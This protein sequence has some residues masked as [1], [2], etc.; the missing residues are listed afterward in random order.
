MQKPLSYLAQA[1]FER[2]LPVLLSQI[3]KQNLGVLTDEDLNALLPDE[4]ADDADKG[5]MDRIARVIE[6]TNREFVCTFDPQDPENIEPEKRAREQLDKEALRRPERDLIRLYLLQ[7]SQTPL[8][9]RRAELRLAKARELAFNMHQRQILQCD[10]VARDAV[11]RLRKM[12]GEDKGGERLLETS[13]TAGKEK[14][15]IK[16]HLGPN[17][18]TADALLRKNEAEVAVLLDLDADDPQRA[19]ILDGLAV[20]REKIA[21]LLHELSVRDK[22]LKPVV[23][24]FEHV[25]QRM[26]SIQRN[27]Q[28][29]QRHTDREPN[30]RHELHE[31]MIVTGE[32][33]ETIA[34]KVGRIRAVRDLRQQI[35]KAIVNANLRLVVSIA[36]KYR[37]RGLPFIDLIQEGNI[38]LIRGVEKYEYRRGYRL[39]T[40]V[41]WWVRQAITR[42]VADK[43]RAIRIP[44]HAFD[45]HVSIACAERLLREEGGRDPTDEEVA[46]RAGKDIQSVRRLRILAKHQIS[47][48]ALIGAYDDSSLGESMSDHRESSPV[49]NAT[50]NVVRKKIDVMLRGLTYRQR[51]IIKLRYGLGDGNPYTLEECGRIFKVTR[52]RIR[53]LEA[54][55]LSTLQARAKKGGLPELASF[56]RSA[57]E[58]DAHDRQSLH[59]S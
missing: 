41:T 6:T 53:Q 8:L 43:A 57:V 56:M 9:T 2:D 4:A 34:D 33:P 39:S 47:M 45:D 55:A 58:D 20:R 14:S 5:V 24:D 15:D 17:L 21:T 26:E 50:D 19:K 23:E 38:G 11:K 49:K 31:L 52:E 29:K 7:M 13:M 54:K 27:L 22:H 32:T 44:Y 46:H 37:N 51:E 18:N 30:L 35:T 25:A 40:Y 36:K 1:E 3:D 12:H 42:A 16:N 59:A 10:P 28:A 48:D